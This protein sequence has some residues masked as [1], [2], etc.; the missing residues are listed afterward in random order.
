M[1]LTKLFKKKPDT[2]SRRVKRL[3]RS[4]FEGERDPETGHWWIEPQEREH[5]WGMQITN[6][7]VKKTNKEIILTIYTERP[8][9][10]IGK[11]AQ[12]LDNLTKWISDRLPIH[13]DNL[14]KKFVIKIIESNIWS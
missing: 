14:N 2:L 8:G 4:Y 9:L 10:M 12:R 3:F 5:L 6:L 1:F 13:E 11:G 7:I